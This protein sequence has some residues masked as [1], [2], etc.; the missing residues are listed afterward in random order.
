MRST[1]R[2]GGISRRRGHLVEEN[3]AS[4]S[5]KDNPKRAQRAQGRQALDLA[6]PTLFPAEIRGK[7]KPYTP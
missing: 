4:R 7:G 3:N 1:A 2:L 5:P 6:L